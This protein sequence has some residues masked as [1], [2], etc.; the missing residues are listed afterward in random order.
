[1][2]TF[3]MLCLAN[4]KKHGGRCVAGLRADGEGW[5]RPVSF[6][7]E[8]TLFDRHCTLDD[9]SLASVLDLIRIRFATPRPEP[10]HP[11]NQLI[12]HTGWQLVSRPAPP[13][14]QALIQ[15]Q[16]VAGPE[17]L[18][19]RSDRIPAETFAASPAPASLALI[20]PDTLEWIIKTN[21]AGERRTR[22]AFTLGGAHSELALTDP[23]WEQRLASL[24]PGAYPRQA[25]ALQAEDA[26]LLTVSLSEPFQS[27]SAAPACCYKLV[28]AV[29]VL[30]RS[31][32]EASAPS[33][34]AEVRSQQGVRP[35][36]EPA[37]AVA[38]LRETHPRAYVPWTLAEDA[39]LA[40]L[41]R[42]G[43]RIAQIAAHLQRRPGA[44][45]SRI[46]K[47]NLAEGA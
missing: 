29:I 40:Q 21:R 37:Y 8:G 42:S 34:Q 5:I 32:Q 11:E 2:P 35:S 19:S 33:E 28:A 30:P 15:T 24:T 6:E 7:R 22:V 38:A 4:S 14:M 16:R 1:M 10:H 46:R 27:D 23:L 25:A 43:H 17:L 26:V 31:W 9:G 39:W 3:E 45:R 12:T 41:V 18:G 20:A 13:T 47:L 36:P 44:I